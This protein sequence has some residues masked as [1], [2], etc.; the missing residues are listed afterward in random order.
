MGQDIERPRHFATLLEDLIGLRA[1]THERERGLS[2][3]AAERSLREA[4]DVPVSSPAEDVAVV[5]ADVLRDMTLH[6]RREAF[7][8]PETI[9]AHRN[10]DVDR[11]MEVRSGAPPDALRRK[12]HRAAEGA[13]NAAVVAHDVRDPARAGRVVQKLVDVGDSAVHENRE[14]AHLFGRQDV[15][16]EN[17]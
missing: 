1:Y 12:H 10:E 11:L 6:V 3:L 16:V 13:R 17:D 8:E 2:I 9:L 14:L 5:A 7:G 4:I 15:L